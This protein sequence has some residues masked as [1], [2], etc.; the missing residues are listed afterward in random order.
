VT[1]PWGVLDPSTTDLTLTL[2]CPSAARP[3]DTIGSPD[4]RNLSFK[5][6]SVMLI[7]KPEASEPT[8]MANVQA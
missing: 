5:V 6:R 7:A 3:S 4:D 1:V 2:S 8:A